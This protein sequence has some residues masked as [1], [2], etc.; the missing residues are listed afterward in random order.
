MG[1][2]LVADD[3]AFLI[4]AI[5]ILLQKEGYTFETACNGMEAI[6]LFNERRFD[7]VITDINMPVKDGYELINH[8]R[9]EKQSNL[10]I[11]VLSSTFDSA[12]Q[13]EGA[14]NRGVSAYVSKM[15]SPL[16]ILT[17]LGK[18]LHAS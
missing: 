6:Q 8:I 7:A 18:Y 11:I 9:S 2:I 10:P 3:H 5:T 13:F 14:Q 15:D 4:K 12:E 17:E 16:R 1:H